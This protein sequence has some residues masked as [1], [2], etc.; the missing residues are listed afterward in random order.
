MYCIISLISLSDRRKQRD[1]MNDILIWLAA[2]GAILG[3]A[4]DAY[5]IGTGRA[6]LPKRACGDK[7]H[8]P[9][10]VVL[11]VSKMA[12]NGFIGVSL[13]WIALK[14][15]NLPVEGAMV[16]AGV[17]GGQGYKL[18][19]LLMDKLYNRTDKVSDGDLL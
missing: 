7:I 17:A 3:F 5:D 19:A 15:M 2:T 4:K 10:A 9:L 8:L 12:I 1:V 18:Y 16:V 14:Y 6:D 13:G 11:T